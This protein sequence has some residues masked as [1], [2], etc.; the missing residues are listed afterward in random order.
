MKT[1]LTRSPVILVE[2]SYFF[3]VNMIVNTAWE[4][5]LVSFMFVAATVLEDNKQNHDANRKNL[6]YVAY[7]EKCVVYNIRPNGKKKGMKT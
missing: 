2:E 6:M 4:R 7:F 5:L 1:L 3:C